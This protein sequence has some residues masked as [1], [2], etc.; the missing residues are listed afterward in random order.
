MN[1]A[2]SDQ[3]APERKAWAN[4]YISNDFICVTTQSGYR[5]SAYDPKGV[6][7]ILAYDVGDEELGAAVLRSLDAS[8]FLAPEEIGSF[9]DLAA[10]E[11][12]YALWVQGLM[13]VVGCESRKE[14]FRDMKLCNIERRSGEIVVTP[15]KHEKL[16]AWGGTGQKDDRVSISSGAAIDVGRGLRVALGRC[17]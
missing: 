17:K 4:A 6:Q 14:L 1:L 9:F 15:T 5:R 11:S 2:I 10:V 3:N 13:Q 12:R 7:S 8:R 16:E